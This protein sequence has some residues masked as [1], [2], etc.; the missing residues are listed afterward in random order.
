MLSTKKSL[1][2]ILMC[3]G[4]IFLLWFM[5][6]Y[7]SFSQG[8]N[9]P[10]NNGFSGYKDEIPFISEI[11]VNFLSSISK[12]FNLI[13]TIALSVIFVISVLLL[14]KHMENKKKLRLEFS[15]SLII[16][17]A[18]STGMSYLFTV[19]NIFY[20]PLTLLFLGSALYSS[21]G[22]NK[23]AIGCAIIFFA[24]LF[25]I[26]S[27]IFAI[28]TVI[29]IAIA[30]KKNMKNAFMLSAAMTI[31]F[32]VLHL[33]FG[34]S[35]VPQYAKNISIMQTIIL[36]FGRLD[37]IAIM[38]FI[39]AILSFFYF[40]WESD[41]WKFVITMFLTAFVL[42]F[43]FSGAIFYLSAFA[44]MLDAGFF[45][46]LIKKKKIISYFILAVFIAGIA[47]SYYQF[48]LAMINLANF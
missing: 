18:L 16:A 32:F 7:M 17:A 38:S 22:I 20:I 42:S 1:A 46:S 24:S 5:P 25:D 35:F 21:K 31:L 27:I 40:W 28:L 43:V 23:Y 8:I 12:N 45:Y 9:L 48:S 41:M 13:V 33:V 34:I 37:G 30:K 11:F 44:I 6:L 19:Q 29:G 14:G 26:I 39:L 10:I 3:L 15:L 47:F 4:V 2:V 36:E